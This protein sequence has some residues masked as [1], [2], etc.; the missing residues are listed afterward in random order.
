MGLLSMLQFLCPQSQKYFR[1][2]TIQLNMKLIALIVLCAGL[3]TV[4]AAPAAEGTRLSFFKNLINQVFLGLD[5]LQKCDPTCKNG[6][7]CIDDKCNCTTFDN[8]EYEGDDCGLGPCSPDNSNHWDCYNA[9]NCHEQP[10]L[11]F[12]AECLCQT[13]CSADP[14]NCFS[15]PH[16][17]FLD[18]C[19]I[20]FENDGILCSDHGVCT[21]DDTASGYTCLCEPGFLGEE[22]ETVDVCYPNQCQNDGLCVVDADGNPTCECQDGYFGEFCQYADPCRITPCYNGGSCS[23]DENQHAVCECTAHWEGDQ[24]EI[25]LLCDPICLNGGLCARDRFD[26]ERC[27]CPPGYTGEQCHNSACSPSPCYN[28]GTCEIDTSGAANCT[29]PAG[30]SG[31]FCEF[32]DCIGVDCGHGNCV[33]NQGQPECQCHN[34][35][36]GPDCRTPSDKTTSKPDPTTEGPTTNDDK[37]TEEDKTTAGPTTEEDKTTEDDKTTEAPT[38]EEEKTTEEDKTTEVPTT[39][40]EKTTEED[41]TTVA[42]TTEEDKTTEEEKTTAE[43]E[44]TTEEAPTTKK[45]FTFIPKDFHEPLRFH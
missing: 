40:E 10:I 24:C 1:I 33:I 21:N 11:P 3:A 8:W 12:G 45:K 2:R 5:P 27:F 28:G 19:R 42:P 37:T 13:D 16:C 9:G 35:W 18:Q 25:E 39:E 29:C 6:A 44:P 7:P 20:N 14:P 17:E 26:Q 36:E 43:P 4:S 15:G 38:T 31:Q 23:I 34:G 30:Y 41:K 32:N 22:C